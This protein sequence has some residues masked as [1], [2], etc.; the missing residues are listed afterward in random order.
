MIEDVAGQGISEGMGCAGMNVEVIL[1]VKDA[2]CFQRLRIEFDRDWCLCPGYEGVGDLAHADVGIVC[3]LH[4]E[5]CRQTLKK[6]AARVCGEGNI[7]HLT[8]LHCIVVIG[9]MQKAVQV[10]DL[11]CIE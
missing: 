11:T 6:R 7:A 8:V 10:G 1:E 4:E 2:N 9:T 3:K 5:E